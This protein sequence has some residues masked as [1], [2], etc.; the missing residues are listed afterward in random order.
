[1][2]ILISNLLSKSIF[3]FGKW[4]NWKYAYTRIRVFLNST[5]RGRREGTEEVLEERVARLERKI[6][7][8]LEN[9]APME[10]KKMEYR[11]K[12]RWK[13]KDLEGLMKER[14]WTDRKSRKS[15]NIEDE[16]KSRQIRYKAVKEIKNEIKKSPEGSHEGQEDQFGKDVVG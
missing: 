4:S 6:T 8:I 14:K 3:D 9:F 2:D 1:M 7:N 15:G 12:P 13:T 11:G 16:L 5:Y 10:V